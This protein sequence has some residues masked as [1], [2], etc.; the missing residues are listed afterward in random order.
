MLRFCKDPFCEDAI[1][2]ACAHCILLWCGLKSR[3]RQEVIHWCQR[4]YTFCKDREDGGL[5]VNVTKGRSEIPMSGPRWWVEEHH[6]AARLSG[7][8]VQCCMRW[9]AMQMQALF[10]TKLSNMLDLLDVSHE[11]FQTTRK[12][13]YQVRWVDKG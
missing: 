11:H 12:A 3:A 5:L 1:H 13:K 9:L 7:R 4:S 2:G 6:M 8:E 10:N